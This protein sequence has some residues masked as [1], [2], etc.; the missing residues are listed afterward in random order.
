MEDLIDSVDV[1]TPQVIIEARI[2]ETSKTFL[3]QY[4]FNWGFGGKLNPS[5]GTGTGLGFPNRLDFT[6]GPAGF[7]PGNP[8]VSTHMANILGT[9]TPH[10]S[11]HP[12]EAGG[13]GDVISAPAAMTQDHV[14]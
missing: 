2:V 10:L 11:L 7:G 6:G 4:G 9:F 12:A 3:Q 14:T 13:L 1:A 5:L 8:V